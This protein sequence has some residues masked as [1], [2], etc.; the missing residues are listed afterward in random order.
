MRVKRSK[1]PATYTL[2]ACLL[3]LSGVLRTGAS[4][5][6]GDLDVSFDPGSGVNGE[7]KAMALQPDGKLIIGGTFTTVRGLARFSLARLDTDGSGDPSFDA[8][9]NVDRYISAI[10]VQPDGKVVFT[11]DYSLLSGE[12][13]GSKVARLNADGSQDSS[14]VPGLETFPSSSAFTCMAVQPDGK[15]VLGGYSLEADEFGNI[16]P[17]SLLIRLNANGSLDDTFTNANG[18]FDAPSGGR[19]FCLALQPDGKILIA[20]AVVT[21][22]NGTN[23]YDLIRLNANGTVDTNFKPVEGIIHSVGL[24]SDGK[25]LLAGYGIGTSTNWN[26]VAR[27]NTDGSI[28]GTFQPGTD[29]ASSL[30]SFVVQPD[31]KVVCIGGYLYVNGADRNGLVRLNSN[32]S[33]DAGFNPTTGAPNNAT[34]VIALQSDG[35]IVI[36]GGFTLANGA[37]RER[38]ARLNSDGTL[39]AGFHPGSSIDAGVSSLAIQSDGKVILGGDFTSVGGAPRNGVARLNANGTLDARFDPGTGPEGSFTSFGASVSVVTLQPDGKV[40]L[41]GDFSSFNGISR[42]RLARLNTDG[43]VDTSFLP[44]TGAPLANY[45]FQP[46]TFLV[47]PDG[48]ILVGGNAAVASNSDGTGLARLNADG[49]FD[50]SFHAETGAGDYTVINSLALEPDGKILAGGY[51]MQSDVPYYLLTRLNADG[52]RDPNLPAAGGSAVATSIALQP[53]GKVIVGGWYGDNQGWVGRFNADGSVDTTFSGGSGA[54]RII[55]SVLLQA[56]GKILIAGSFTSFN[57]TNCGHVARLNVDG[58]LD[59][60]FNPGTDGSIDSIALQ[61]DGNL[62]ISGGNF[63]TVNGAVR[64]RVARLLG[65][66][67]GPSNIPPSVNIGSPLEGAIYA[68]RATVDIDVDA[69]DNDGSVTRVDF[70][71]GNRLL[72]SDTEPPFE[73]S[74]EQV[75]PGNYVLTADAI[76]N[77]GATS[78]SAA[79]NIVVTNTPPLVAIT[80]PASGSTLRA[81]ASVVVS[82]D[83]SDTDG[84]IARVEVYAGTTLVGSVS[85]PPFEVTWNVTAPGSYSLSAVAIDNLGASA[86]SA[87]VDVTVA[88]PLPPATPSSLTVTTISVSRIDLNWIDNAANE[89]GFTIERSKNGKP[90][91]EIARVGPN[92]STF[93]N[94]GL[95]KGNQYSYRVRAYNVAGDS[96]HSNAATTK[97]VRKF[98]Q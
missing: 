32:G 30:V 65:N 27:L 55:K 25:I 66:F 24:Q 61:P 56:D 63:T 29:N 79:V 64:P 14:F 37:N 87:S 90:F 9:T 83:A 35:R 43:T 70:Y 93:S 46:F 96:A 28:D 69:S 73:I 17:H 1:S 47:Q 7:V 23:H 8:G 76:D 10:A 13:Q 84:T 67:G 57:G 4:A 85:A 2:A 92:V 72:V 5:A 77:L 54:D 15:I 89:S 12:A 91:K 6:P 18:K 16:Y 58:G 34:G 94:T 49:S 97:T 82:A 59:S 39:D 45:A 81:P 53:D 41:G 62:L 36:G 48:K 74:W 60:S 38:L 78:T 86:R 19:I 71:A 44:W 88:P 98:I 31:G 42:N 26:G 33:V 21:S 40:L 3:L 22:V 95:G 20:G 11:R 52:S 80:Q 75:P 68:G 50:T 51:Y